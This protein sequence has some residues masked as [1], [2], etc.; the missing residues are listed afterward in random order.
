MRGRELLEGELAAEDRGRAQ[1]LLAALGEALEAAPDDLAH[2]VGDAHAPVLLGGQPLGGEG[3]LLDEEADD[4]GHEER[5]AL[6][7]AVDGGDQGLGWRD[8]GG[9]GDEAADVVGIEAAQQDP[10]VEAL[11]GQLG[12]GGARGWP[13]VSSTS[14]Y[15]PRTRSRAPSSSRARNSRRRE[16]ARVGPV[17]VVE[18]EHDR[19]VGRGCP[20]ERGDRIEEPEAGLGGLG[21][22]ECR[23]GPAAWR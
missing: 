15:V 21:R 20:Q 12:Q 3:T 17:E 10:L 5:V 23:A 6:G 11:P 8:A 1:D 4:L 9:A 18:D 16:G 19:L 7:V 2:A 22:G 13:L 14:R